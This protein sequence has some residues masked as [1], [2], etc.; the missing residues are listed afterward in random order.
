MEQFLVFRA[1]SV[2]VSERGFVIYLAESDRS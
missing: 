1:F 2:N